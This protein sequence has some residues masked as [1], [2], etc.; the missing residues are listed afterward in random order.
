V[1]D[2]KI[3]VMYLIGKRAIDI[4][5]QNGPGFETIMI[6]KMLSLLGRTMKTMVMTCSK[7]APKLLPK[8]L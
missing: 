8:L 3:K 6:K 1:F 2:I 7:K 4:S 5:A